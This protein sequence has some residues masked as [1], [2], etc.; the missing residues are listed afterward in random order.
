MSR[1]DTSAWLWFVLI[2]LVCGGGCMTMP[3]MPAKQQD[4]AVVG[5]DAHTR[6]RLHGTA[7]PRPGDPKP[8]TRLAGTLHVCALPLVDDFRYGRPYGADTSPS[9]EAFERLAGLEGIDHALGLRI[10]LSEQLEQRREQVREG[11]QPD[12]IDVARLIFDAARQYDSDLLLVYTT[13]HE[14]SQFDLTGN[15]LQV[16]LLGFSPTVVANGDAQTQA[17]L[18]DAKTGYIY[19]LTG[20]EGDGMAMGRGWNRAKTQRSAATRASKDA[21]D[22][23][24]DRL[25]AAWPALRAAY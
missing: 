24:V 9:A 7:D 18:I 22:E 17:V 4:L 19:A 11:K 2:V 23:V 21:F 16:L 13:G 8:G 15:I 10:D 14:A 6:D 1:P 3:Y 25:V 5:L 12:P 20:G